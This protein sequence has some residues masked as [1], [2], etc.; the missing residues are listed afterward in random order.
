VHIAM[1]YLSHAL[2]GQPYMGVGRNLAYRRSLFIDSGGFASHYHLSGGDDDLF[3]NHNA[4][5]STTKICVAEDAKTLSFSP[6]DLSYWLR[7]KRRHLSTGFY[8]K[9]K[10]KFLLGL[11]STSQ[12]LFIAL[13]F[14]LLA[15][16]FNILP[17]CALVFFRVLSQLIIFKK[18]MQR[19][20]EKKLLLFSPVFEVFFIIFNFSLAIANLFK[21][22]HKW[23]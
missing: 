5:G 15:S 16:T 23:K 14:F 8:Y 9:A 10:H 4:K 2:A 13:A 3:V 22:S 20:S 7:Q 21:R 19:L 18:S 6:P 1:Q 11:W 12:V 17:V